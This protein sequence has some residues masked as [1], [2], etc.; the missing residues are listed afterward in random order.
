MQLVARGILLPEEPSCDSVSASDLDFGTLSLDSGMDR[1]SRLADS[2]VQ[3]MTPGNASEGSTCGEP[4][5]GVAGGSGGLSLS[6]LVQAQEATAGNTA[7]NIC[8]SQE[9]QAVSVTQRIS[10][11][12]LQ[13]SNS[14]S[15][16]AEPSSDESA[17]EA[18]WLQNPTDDRTHAGHQGTAAESPNHLRQ[19]EGC[20]T[21]RQQLHASRDRSQAATAASVQLSEAPSQDYADTASLCQHSLPHEHRP[22]SA[23]AVELASGSEQPASQPAFRQLPAQ[24]AVASAAWNCDSVAHID[25]HSAASASGA[26]LPSVSDTEHDGDS[27]TASE[28]SMPQP[29]RQCAESSHGSAEHH[30]SDQEHLESAADA[31]NGDHASLSQHEQ[32]EGLLSDSEDEFERSLV[33][34]RLLRP[35]NATQAAPR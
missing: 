11:K 7:G 19:I 18:S 27:V 26:V 4:G 24:H 20:T 30:V 22:K 5:V 35:A 14:H 32:Q 25:F 23:S 34:A 16:M 13:A 10:Q 33:S 3:G 2:L 8:S 31:C 21:K 6:S 9:G 15:D 28:A 29:A 1:L 12:A 17:S